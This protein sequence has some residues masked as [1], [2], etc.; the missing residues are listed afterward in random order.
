MVNLT[1][2]KL[3]SRERPK[4]APYLKLNKLC[5]NLGGKIGEKIWEQMKTLYP[6]WNPG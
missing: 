3:T 4:S 2:L 5:E 1:M 6:N